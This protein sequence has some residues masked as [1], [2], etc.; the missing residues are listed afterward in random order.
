MTRMRVLSAFSFLL[1]LTPAH[2]QRGQAPA[3][4]G[5]GAAP[6]AVVSPEIGSD[7]RVTFRLYAP[8]ATTVT[9][10]GEWS[11]G[12][13]VAMTKD[14]DGVWSVVTGPIAVEAYFY[15]FTVDGAR[16]DDPANPRRNVLFLPGSETSAFAIKDIPHGDIREV[17][18]SSPT[19]KTRRRML[20]YTPPGYDRS[21]D[22]YPVLYLLHG[23]GG[24]EEEWT[25][26]GFLPQIMDSLLAD[27]KI[28]PMLVVMPNGHPDEPA[29]PHVLPENRRSTLPNAQVSEMHTRLSSQGMLDDV[30]PFVEA[31]YRVKANRENRAIAGLSMGGEQATFIGL[32]HLD[33]FAWIGS[34]SGA[35]VMLPGRGAPATIAENFPQLTAAATKPLRLLYFSCGTDDSLIA[36]NRDMKTWLKSKQIGFVDIETPGYAHV[37]R[38]WRVSLLDFAPRLF[39]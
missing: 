6:P 17:W 26:A 11:G 34:F 16:I 15:S 28:T 4:P 14:A 12:N 24:D 33:R 5:R 21:K 13:N 23:W 3:A 36:V 20:V 37:W 39:R 10:N 22:S 2:A 35:F 32:N 25:N 18:Y 8:T 1:L 27:R 29:A 9:V 19:M 31:N 38:Y 7:R 30:M